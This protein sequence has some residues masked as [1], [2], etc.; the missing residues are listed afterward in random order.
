[1][2]GKAGLKAGLIGGGVLFVLTLLNLIRIPFL[3][4]ICCG[5]NILVYLGA[6]ALAANFLAP[7]RTAGTSAGA[8]AVA[9][10]V[11]GAIGGLVSL[12]I[13]AIQFAV[14][15]GAAGAMSYLDPEVIR[16]LIDAG[17]DPQMFA[18]LSGI[19]GVLLGGGGCC[20]LGIGI[21][22]GLGA[23]GGMIFSAIKSD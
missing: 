2:T 7:P 15:G 3:G 16:M 17:V 14:G 22:A 18:T 1:M 20:L 11:S 23:I 19:G 10:L 13:G 5:L 4:C 12:I 6:G 9:G 21:G 8:G